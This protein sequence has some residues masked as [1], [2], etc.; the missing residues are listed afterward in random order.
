MWGRGEHGWNAAWGCSLPNVGNSVVTRSVQLV[1]S[2]ASTCMELS[3]RNP[4]KSTAR[5]TSLLTFD[6]RVDDTASSRF[7]RCAACL[8]VTC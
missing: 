8:V 6:Q 2:L 7:E 5:I 4:I 3:H 1:R